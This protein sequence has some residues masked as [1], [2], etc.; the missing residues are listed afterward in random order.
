[1]EAPDRVA[2][3]FTLGF[4]AVGLGALIAYTSAGACFDGFSGSREGF[5]GPVRTGGPDCIRSLDDTAKL[6]DLLHSKSMKTEE[7]PDDLREL[8]LILSKL[9]C[10]KRDLMGNGV[11]NA[12]LRQPF[13]T[14]HDLEPVA[15]TTTRCFAKTIPQRDLQLALDKWGTRGTFLIKRICTA[16]SLSDV[17]EKEALRLFGSAM[18]DVNDVA[19]GVCCN[20]ANPVIA[21]AGVGRLPGGFEPPALV[22]LKEYKGY[23]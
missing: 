14:S 23:Y 12:T 7:G 8:D 2:Q 17:E 4:I 15:E 1:M 6:Y 16:T 9:A 3:F 19:L 10:F 20:A 18:Y 13:S 11:V 21:A 22:S 5:A